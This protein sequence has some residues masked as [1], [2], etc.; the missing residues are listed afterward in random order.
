VTDIVYLSTNNWSDIPHAVD[1]GC[2]PGNNSN[3]ANN[4]V[5]RKASKLLVHR[6]ILVATN[7]LYK[8]SGYCMPMSSHPV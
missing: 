1:Y 3:T 6:E 4:Y 2:T 7:S 8:H 5:V